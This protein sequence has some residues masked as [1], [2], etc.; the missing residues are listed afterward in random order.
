LNS[1]I[2]LDTKLIGRIEGRFFIPSY[3]RGYRWGQEEVKRLLDDI[4]ANGSKNYCLQPLVVKRLSEKDVSEKELE[5]DEWFEVIDGQQ[6]LTTL[7]LIYAYLY[8]ESG[9]FFFKEPAFLLVYETRKKSADF[10]KSLDMTMK[11]ENI[12]F[13]FI[14]NAY[15]TIK[16]WFDSKEDKQNAMINIYKYLSEN[17]KVIWYEV[18]KNEDAIA[19]FTRLN[20][21]K[22]K[23]TNA[24]LVK[25]LFLSQGSASNMTTEKQEEIALQWDNIERELQNDT[26]WYFLSNYTKKEYQTRID[27]ILD[28]IAQKDSE[29]REE[30]Y[31]FFHFDGLRKKE[32]L[33]NIWRTIQRTFLNLKDWFENHELYH[34]IGYLIASE[35]VS[36]QEIYK[37]SLDKTKNQFITELDNAIKKSINISNNYADLSYE[38]DADRKDLYRLLLLFNIESVRQ[39]GEQTQWFPFDKFKLQESGRITWSLEH[40]HAQQSEGLRTEASWREWLRLHLSSIKSLYGEE[41]LTAEI[42]TLLDRPKFERMEFE[43]V[44]SKVVRRLSVEGNTEYL[45]SIANLALLNMSDNAALSNSTFDVKRNVIIEMDKKGQ[46]IPFCTK[47]V[48]L[49]YYTPSKDNQLHFWGQT[50]RIAYV[51]A[52]NTVL[53]SYLEEPIQ[54]EME[55]V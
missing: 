10:L 2:I 51:K 36:L 8:K 42:Q 40:I 14:C 47:M 41:A 16:S 52:M 11:C 53:Q 28:L 33:D 3:Q 24:E 55:D 37:T 25:A 9:G 12:D 38:K 7:Y 22:I 5:V 31:T 21:G 18:D 44:Q 27:L 54:H 23:L 15:E 29:N 48:F 34:K 32:S 45:H 17:V 43:T 39:N 20:I 13:W 19:L 30:Y 26:L 1:E 4:Y 46:Y 35:C 6:R 50:D 49:K